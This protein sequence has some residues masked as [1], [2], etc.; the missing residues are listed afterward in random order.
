MFAVTGS[1]HNLSYAF[2]AVAC[3]YVVV[4][5][6]SVELTFNI[7]DRIVL[8][9]REVQIIRECVNPYLARWTRL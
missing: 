2:V 4:A 3:I 1:G 7:C 6:V 9:D 5:I 8:K